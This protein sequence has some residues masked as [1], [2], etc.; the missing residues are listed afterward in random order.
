[1]DQKQSSALRMGA[2]LLKY[3]RQEQPIIPG[4]GTSDHRSTT[5][6]RPRPKRQTAALEDRVCG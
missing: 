4:G 1:M 6:H 5:E 3:A 2:L